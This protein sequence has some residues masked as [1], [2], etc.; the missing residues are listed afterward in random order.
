MKATAKG[1]DGQSNSL[2]HPC[3]LCIGLTW[4]DLLKSKQFIVALKE[5]NDAATTMYC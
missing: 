3:T 2:Q 5:Y 4:T 1:M